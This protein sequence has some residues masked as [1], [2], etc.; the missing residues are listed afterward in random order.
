LHAL[1]RKLRDRYTYPST[2]FVPPLAGLGY[3]FLKI[4]PSVSQVV[5]RN[6][7]ATCDSTS[8]N[9]LCYREVNFYNNIIIQIE[10]AIVI[11]RTNHEQRIHVFFSD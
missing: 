2:K 3:F 4:F 6:G 9:N 10:D 11:Q 1:S 5:P 7:Q 8:L